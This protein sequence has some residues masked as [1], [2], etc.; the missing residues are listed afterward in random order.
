MEAAR[1]HDEWRELGPKLPPL[2]AEVTLKVARTELPNVVHPVSQEVLLLLEIYTRV[3]DVVDHCSCPDYQVLRTLQTLSE[4]G[5]VEVR[6]GPGTPAREAGLLSRAQVRRMREWLAPSS[7]EPAPLRD[8]K[9]LLF[10]SDAAGT[11]ELLRLLATLP[12]ASVELRFAERRLHPHDLGRVG[13]L[14]VDPQLAIELIHVP[15][16]PAFAPV[17]PLAAHG[18]LGAVL[19]V[20]GNPAQ[21]AREL[22]PAVELLRSLPRIRLIPLL[23][24][25]PG[26]TALP[27]E[28]RESLALFEDASPVFLSLADRAEGLR[29]VLARL[30]P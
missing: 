7:R 3:R 10:S 24:G 9:L 22:A 4:R 11:Q 15:S 25:R 29:S 26:E 27:D 30:V 19:L 8:P 17:W 1:Q 13:R 14:R 6:K 20:A 21:A 23:L 16:D 12:G 28:V 5:I 18:A 2:D